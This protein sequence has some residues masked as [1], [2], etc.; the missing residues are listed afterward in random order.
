[1]RKQLARLIELQKIESAAGRIHAKRK[2]LPVQMKT[3]EEEFNLFCEFA[4]TQR[5]QMESVRKRRQE[6]DAQLQAG[7]ETLKRTRERLFEVQSEVPYD[8]IRKRLSVQ[9]RNG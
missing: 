2:N 9:I 7:Q 5:E 6:K 3:L 4:E 1:M 8:F